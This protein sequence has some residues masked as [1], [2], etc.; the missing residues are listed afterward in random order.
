MARGKKFTADQII[1]KLR[2]AE[3][4]ISQGGTT[5]AAAKK[6]GVAV[7]TFFRCRKEYGGYSPLAMRMVCR[8]AKFS[9]SSFVP[10]GAWFMLSR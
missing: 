1:P 8:S 7:Q 9:A 10:A 4:V 6:I 5:A 3:L 2:E